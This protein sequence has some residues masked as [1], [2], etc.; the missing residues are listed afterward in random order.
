MK[1]A[2]DV[3]K[4]VKSKDV[5]CCCCVQQR[6]ASGCAVCLLVFQRGSVGHSGILP[7]SISQRMCCVVGGELVPL[8]VSGEEVMV[9]KLLCWLLCE[10]F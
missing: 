6:N 10:T 7:C 3:G 2:S 8:S 5:V 9:L 1:F 4:E